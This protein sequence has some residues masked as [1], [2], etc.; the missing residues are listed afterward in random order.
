MKRRWTHA[1]LATLLVLAMSGV[2]HA[3]GGA[4]DATLEGTV[5]LADGT[6]APGA[7]VT[8][9]SPALQG[10]RS[11][12]TQANGSYILRGL[13]PGDYHLRF[14]LQGFKSTEV[15]ATVPL[16][17]HVRQDTKLA[18]ETVTE[19]IVVT[20]TAE[21]ALERP[22]VGANL[23]NKTVDSLATPRDIAD[24]AAL[25]PGANT[26]TP[27]AGQIQISGGEPYDNLFLLNGV[28]INDNVFG[29][30][31]DLYIEDAVQETQ[32]LSSAVS[33]EYGR[34]GG[35]VI[36]AITKSGG[37]V[38]S[39]TF[40]TDLSNPKYRSN[41]PLED[42][43]GIKRTDKN[44]LIYSATL[45]GYILKD[46]LWFFLAGRNQS[47]DTQEALFATGT[48]FDSLNDNKR[49]EGKLTANF[50]N[51]H[52][53]QAAYTNND[54]NAVA[55]SVD[56]QT[57][58]STL[59]TVVHPHYPNS[60]EVLHYSGVLSS[61]FFL[62]GQYS[63]KKFRFENAGGTLTD[64]EDS[65]F[66]CLTAFGG[67]CVYNAPVFDST[68]PESRNNKQYAASGSYF[69]QAAGSHDIKVGGERFENV[70]TGGNSQ[71]S[72]GYE[73]L[74]DPLLDAN[75]NIV[76]DANGRAIP[77]FTPGGTLL[78]N[79]IASRGATSTITNNA[80][81]ANDD[82]RLNNH[83]SF[84]LGLRYGKDSSEATGG[85][86]NVNT[87]ALD[88]RLALTFDPLAN[89]KF[90]LAASYAEY[91]GSYSYGIFSN[92]TLSSPEFLYGPY[93]GP[94]GQGR[95]FAPGFE[96][97]NYLLTNAGGGASN[98]R[99]ADNVGAPR[100]KEETVSAGMQLSRA[101][102]L[103]LTFINR[104]TNNLVEPFTT[105]ALGSTTVVINGVQGPT[106]PNVLY[107][108]SNIPKRQYRALVLEGRQTITPA[109]TIEGNW[110]HELR[111]NGNYE[112]QVGQTFPSAGVEQFPE[113]FDKART[114]PEG[115]LQDFEQDIVRAWTIYNFDLHRGGALSLS[116]LGQYNSPLTY[117]LAATGVPLT[118][119]QQ[120][121]GAAYAQLP[122]TQ[123]IF[124]GSRGSQE[125]KAW[126]TFNVAALYSVPIF[127]SLSPYIKVDVRNVLNDHT[128][129]AWDTTVTPDPNSPKDALGLP[130]G[131][132]KSANFGKAQSNLN[133]PIPREYRFSAGIRF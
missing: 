118:A 129:I 96:L 57:E 89:G 99:F 104:D 55:T 72:T 2:A 51:S 24:I 120:A 29:N 39:G 54:T 121:L 97:G 1:L 76:L 80:V 18:P 41:T 113:I 119:T 49:Y 32:V 103:R 74:T 68:D 66:S 73:F 8:I 98:T 91:V 3:Q 27:L 64:I 36:N 102:F 4:F 112:G 23:T 131:F 7:L 22:T 56:A 114:F 126:T 128:L 117:S 85:I 9:S 83:W 11:A 35:G 67:A 50:S 63:Q 14:E 45:G 37:N 52:S 109:W 48:K 61:S 59:D 92:G 42:Q 122:Q 132:I 123:T 95:N 106:V 10:T 26:N 20:G 44:N 100:V 71:S 133:Y 108:N 78:V 33:A 5:S 77:T 130:T 70:R 81:Y 53:L 82:W 65:P 25:A 84:N 19:T 60:L 13:P 94:A 110:A 88:P 93:V 34:F 101:G 40:R 125:F 21:S 111:E 28:D 58:A 87:S 47:T 62:E 75:G 38:F 6:P 43:E 124:F 17:G 79:W 31:D 69:L 16:G 86:R 30:P 12:T 105:L 107:Q 90:R 15:V 115:R 116:L 127:R 46:K